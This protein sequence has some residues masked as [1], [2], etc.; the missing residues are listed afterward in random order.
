MAGQT[1]HSYLNHHEGRRCGITAP[2]FTVTKRAAE[3]LPP[4]RTIHTCKHPHDGQERCILRLPDL[5]LSYQCTT[6]RYLFNFST[7]NQFLPA[8]LP[9][10]FH[11]SK[12]SNHL[13]FQTFKLVHVG[14][15]LWGT[16][17]CR[18]PTDVAIVSAPLNPTNQRE[19]IVAGPSRQSY[20][21]WPHQLLHFHPL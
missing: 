4:F 5:C 13:C 18:L 6:P 8:P 10:A 17:D 7:T 12:V 3:N 19:R 14:S 15:S 21:Y 11:P 1:D 20:C 2:L 16:R 9:R